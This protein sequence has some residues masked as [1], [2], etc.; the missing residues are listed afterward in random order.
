MGG[1]GRKFWTELLT[2]QNLVIFELSSLYL[3]QSSQSPEKTKTAGPEVPLPQAALREKGKEV[4]VT[5]A[6]LK[7]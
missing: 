5:A 4:E 2:P 6:S 7:R 1:E 3:S